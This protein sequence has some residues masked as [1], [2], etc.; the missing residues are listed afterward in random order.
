VIEAESTSGELVGVVV[1]LGGQ[2]ALGLATGLK[3]AGVTILGTSPEAI[4]LAE[5][6]GLFAGILDD[7]GLLA[8]R[9]GTAY[10]LAGA[11]Q[12]AGEIGYPVLV[13]PS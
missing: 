13:R 5:E 10:D 4:D 2:T 8:P 3:E 12:V 6:R 7:A 11:K 1:Q 9:N